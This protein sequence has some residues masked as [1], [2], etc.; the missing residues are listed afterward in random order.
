MSVNP[1]TDLDL[2]AYCRR[3]LLRLTS[4]QKDLLFRLDD[5]AIGAWNG[6]RRE[7]AAAQQAAR[8]EAPVQIPASD[9]K[10][11]KG[12]FRGLAVKVAARIDAAARGADPETPECSTSS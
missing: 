4:W 6:R 9:T 12:M 10:T 2:E 1:L 11:L 8:D 3:R 7:A 5:A